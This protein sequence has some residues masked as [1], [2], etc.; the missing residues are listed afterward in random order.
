LG[1]K[2]ERKG[3]VAIWLLAGFFVLI[4]VD[5]SGLGKERNRW[6]TIIEQDLSKEDAKGLVLCNYRRY[7]C[8]HACMHQTYVVLL[9]TMGN[10]PF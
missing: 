2:C 6:N 9:E 8:L 5:M 3:I 1:V 4:C 7:P 10:P